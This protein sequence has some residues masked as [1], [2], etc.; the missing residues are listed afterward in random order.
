MFGPEEILLE[1][2]RYGNRNELFVYSEKS[3]TFFE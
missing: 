2:A 3:V 1:V